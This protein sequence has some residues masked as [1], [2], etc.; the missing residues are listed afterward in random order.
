MAFGNIKIN[1]KDLNPQQAIGLNLPLNGEAIFIP[2]YQ[3]KDTIKYNLINYLLTNP[4]ERVLNPEFG[5]GIREYIFSQIEN[6][7]LS[8]LKEDLQE[9]INLNFNNIELQDLQVTSNKDQNQINI[10]LKYN[11]LG[12]NNEDQVEL[13]FQ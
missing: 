1:P 12:T 10:L 4:G 9:K 13:T 5:V 6:E 8:F 11:I 3:T 2:N 7:N